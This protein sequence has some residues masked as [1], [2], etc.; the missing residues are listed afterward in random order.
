M[1]SV[2]IQ[3]VKDIEELKKIDGVKSVKVV[4]TYY[5]TMNSAKD[6]TQAVET[7]KELG[8]KGEGMVVSIIDSGIDPNHKDMKITDSSKAKLKKKI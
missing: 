6:L 1:D 8:L 5:P 7:W 4:K 3:K 2:S